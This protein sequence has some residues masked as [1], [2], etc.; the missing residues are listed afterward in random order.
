MEVAYR[1]YPL[2]DGR[3]Y[4]EADFKTLEDVVGLFDYCQIMEAM[5]SKKGWDFLISRFGMKGLYEADKKSGWL[6]WDGD[7]FEK[8]AGDV[9]YER[10]IVAYDDESDHK[11]ITKFCESTH[12][13]AK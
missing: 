12:F 9:M 10:D 13:P 5:I 6:Y 4:T 8:F 1:I 7:S 3:V 11:A 2:P